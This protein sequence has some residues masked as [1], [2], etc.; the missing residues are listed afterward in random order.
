MVF[1][2]V[3]AQSMQE[4]Y[5]FQGISAGST[6]VRVR[7]GER[8]QEEGNSSDDLS[9]GSRDD[10]S[11]RFLDRPALWHALDNPSSRISNLD[12]AHPPQGKSKFLH[13]NFEF[14]PSSGPG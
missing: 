2:M 3:L 12:F 10:R 11:G 8:R 5:V 6:W 13:L 9:T 4:P 7:V 14:G 1:P